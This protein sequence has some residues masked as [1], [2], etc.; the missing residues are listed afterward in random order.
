MD[1]NHQT[2]LVRETDERHGAMSEQDLRAACPADLAASL[3]EETVGLGM[4]TLE[5][6]RTID[7]RQVS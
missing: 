4:E 5:W 7:F 2:I 3:F 6:Y 1:A